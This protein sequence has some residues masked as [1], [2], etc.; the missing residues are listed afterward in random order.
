VAD[1]ITARQL[2]EKACAARTV[3]KQTGLRA[4]AK[5]SEVEFTRLC[6]AGVVC[7]IIGEAKGPRESAENRA[8]VSLDL[9]IVRAMEMKEKGVPCDDTFEGMPGTRK[10]LEAAGVV[11]EEE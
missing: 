4:A 11:F 5:D 6:N 8:K 2:V 1:G 3:D 10:M 9:R 7:S